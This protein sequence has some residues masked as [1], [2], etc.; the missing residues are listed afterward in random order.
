[1]DGPAH[2]RD[3]RLPHSLGRALFANSLGTSVPVQELRA[4]DFYG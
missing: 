1:V 3:P 2:T 4:N